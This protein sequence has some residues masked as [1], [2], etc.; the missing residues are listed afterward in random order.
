MKNNLQQNKSFDNLIRDTHILELF[1]FD[2]FFVLV[3]EAKFFQRD[4]D[5]LA[6][7]VHQPAQGGGFLQG[8]RSFVSSL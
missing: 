1:V 4:A 5:L 3:R 6:V 2:Q 7:H 8:K